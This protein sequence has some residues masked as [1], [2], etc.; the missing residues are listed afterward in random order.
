MR[1]E[2]GFSFCSFPKL[3]GKSCLWKQEN[4]LCSRGVVLSRVLCHHHLAP[5]CSTDTRTICWVSGNLGEAAAA[6]GDSLLCW[7]VN[8]VFFLLFNCIFHFYPLT[9]K[10]HHLKQTFRTLNGKVTALERVTAGR[11]LLSHGTA[12][13]T[14]MDS[15]RKQV[16]LGAGP[17]PPQILVILLFSNLEHHFVK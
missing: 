14:Q 9:P 3:N 15:Y 5:L 16:D 17:Q 4:S 6:L 8:L 11:C 13:K 10:C 12:W 2:R 7:G 1:A